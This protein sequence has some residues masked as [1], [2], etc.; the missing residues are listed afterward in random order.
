M[1]EF[2]QFGYEKVTMDSICAKHKI[3]KGMMYHYYSGKD[4]LFLL[5]VQE[6]YTMMQAYIEERISELKKK[7]ALEALKG[8]W[9]LRESFFEQHPEQKN[10]FENALLRTPE[11]LS[12]KI[13]EIRRPIES[14]NR[15]FLHETLGKIELRENLKKEN[16]SIYL[17]AMESVFWKL[18]DQYLSKKL[19]SDVHSMMETA[20]ELWV[21]LGVVRQTK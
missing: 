16:T 5:C 20:G 3:S 2:S 1:E 21:L 13:A 19:V 7:E 11:H 8:F 18:V 15:R 6:M 12:E 4:D 17:E 10:I 14:L 9:T